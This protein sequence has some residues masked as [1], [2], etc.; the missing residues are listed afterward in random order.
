MRN[1]LAKHGH[2][3]LIAGLARLA[4]ALMFMLT[5]SPGW[6]TA[7]CS[8]GGQPA[9]MT[10]LMPGTMPAPPKPCC[11]KTAPACP[12]GAIAFSALPLTAAAPP[13][14]SLMGFRYVAKTQPALLGQIIRPISPPPRSVV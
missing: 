4:V 7:P 12:C 1:F 8:T 13:V 10:M 9:A 14:V 5:S 3:R 2:K 6:A 11:P